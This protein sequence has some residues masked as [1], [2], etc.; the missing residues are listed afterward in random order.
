MKER[1]SYITWL[2]LGVFFVF[3][4]MVKDLDF[5][6]VV[7]KVQDYARLFHI[8]VPKAFYGIGAIVLIG[9]E[10]TIGF[11]LIIGIFR[12]GTF[13]LMC[14]LV[15]F[16]LVLTF[17]TAISGKLDDCGCFGTFW[18]T[19]PW[20]SFIKNVVLL[21]LA[22]V[23]Y[24]QTSHK[25]PFRYSDLTICTGCVLVLCGFSLF[26]QPLKDSSKFS[27][28]NNLYINTGSHSSIDV[29][30]IPD[31]EV[32]ISCIGVIRRM[33]DEVASE[34]LQMLTTENRKP[35]IITSSIPKDVTPDIYNHATV[36][37]MDNNTLNQLMSSEGG[38]ITR[39]EKSRIIYKWQKDCFNFQ[40]YKHDEVNKYSFGEL[41]YGFIWSSVLFFSIYILVSS[42]M[43]GLPKN[44]SKS[45]Q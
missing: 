5:F 26:N 1:V 33:D 28:G 21:L 36:G 10:L 30:F 24:P 18:A 45:R 14:A 29:D 13:I 27:V 44:A 7:V 17:Y 34:I 3:S 25:T 38:I 2:F 22:M 8:S 37:F 43:R 31:S 23:A 15:I 4:A 16:F 32:D 40:S 12:R 9:T 35:T 39:D 19:T 42:I 11:L 20:I 6:S 41:T